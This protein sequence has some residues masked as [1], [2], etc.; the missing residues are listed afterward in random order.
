MGLTKVRVKLVNPERGLTKD[1]ELL[2]DTGSVLTWVKRSVL[3]GLGIAPC[4]VR[5]IKTITGE[6]VERETGLVTLVLGESE[7]DVEVV[8]EEEGDGEVLGVVA[9]ESLGYT[10]NSVTGKVEYVGYIT[11]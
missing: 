8:F 10:I 6:V 4:R 7:A 9:L 11:Y 5:R 2:V 3:E 1:V